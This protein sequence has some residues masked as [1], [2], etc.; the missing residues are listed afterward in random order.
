MGKAQ[1]TANL[2]EGL[3]QARITYNTTLPAARKAALEARIPALEQK[4][5]AAATARQTAETNVTQ[6]QTELNQLIEQLV[7]ATPETAPAIRDSI[8]EKTAAA[9]PLADIL[10]AARHE[11]ARL[12]LDLAEITTEITRLEALLAIDDTRN[13]WCADHS[14]ALSGLV[15][16]IEINGEPGQILIAPNGSGEP[17]ALLAGVEAMTTAGWARNFALHPYWQKYKPTYRTGLIL[18]LS[19]DIATVSLDA[20]ASSYQGL[21][22]NQGEILSNVPI[23]YMGCNGVAFEVGDH[24]VV[25]LEGQNW[26]SPAVIGF[27][28]SPKPCGESCPETD[29]Y[30]YADLYLIESW[31]TVRVPEQPYYNSI[32]EIPEQISVEKV[33]MLPWYAT[34]LASGDLLTFGTPGINEFISVAP[35]LA[36]LGEIIHPPYPYIRHINIIGNPCFESYRHP[37]FTWDY[38]FPMM[39]YFLT[40][41]S[42]V[43]WTEVGPIKERL[44][45]VRINTDVGVFEIIGITAEANPDTEAYNLLVRRIP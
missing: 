45:G 9:R 12:A 31:V 24:V 30:D 42:V 32:E 7:A 27:V 14:T 4:I 37:I 11:E 15:D 23:Q 19:E 8:T 21:P 3:Y 16:T 6:A 35:C 25:R 43:V 18:S 26:N 33:I 1:I 10:T 2:G 5:T 28:A 13:I 38:G 44:C 41:W 39:V 34:H 20:A 40:G 29:P 17:A 22:I 36:R